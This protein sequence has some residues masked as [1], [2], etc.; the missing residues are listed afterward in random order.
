MAFSSD[1]PH[2]TPRRSDRGPLTFKREIALGGLE[3][4]LFSLIRTH[5]KEDQYKE[6]LKLSDRY[7]RAFPKGKY[8]ERIAYYRGWLP[9]DERRCSEALHLKRY[10]KHFINAALM[11]E[12]SSPGATLETRNGARRSRPLRR[13]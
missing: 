5:V 4:A 3:K 7:N 13:S 8:A 6:A 12:A 1:R 2:Q 11:S 9:Y 10:V